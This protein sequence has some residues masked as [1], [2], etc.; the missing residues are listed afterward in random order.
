MA[1]LVLPSSGRSIGETFS[2]RSNIH[3]GMRLTRHISVPRKF[4]L[5]ELVIVITVVA[6]VAVVGIPSAAIR[7]ATSLRAGDWLARPRCMLP[8]QRRSKYGEANQ[9]LPAYSQSL[10]Y[11]SSSQHS[12]LK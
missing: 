7:C 5:V 8:G 11:G 10:Q 2:K 1:W 9:Q 4:A 6:T 3:H 12:G